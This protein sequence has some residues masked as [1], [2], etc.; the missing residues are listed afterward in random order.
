MCQIQAYSLVL[1][2]IDYLA[3]SEADSL[4]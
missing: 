1:L 3:Y 4:G 2:V